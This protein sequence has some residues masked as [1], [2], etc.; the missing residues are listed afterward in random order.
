[1]NGSAAAFNRIPLL[2]KLFGRNYSRM[3]TAGT[4][5][6]YERHLT[7]LNDS[8]DVWRSDNN[9]KWQQW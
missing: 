1:M 5:K 3:D 4:G 9:Y 8:I 2:L 6:I 7:R